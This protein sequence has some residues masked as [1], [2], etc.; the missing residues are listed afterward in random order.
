MKN[1]QSKIFLWIT[2][3]HCLISKNV[4]FSFQFVHTKSSSS[5]P[6]LPNFPF[7]DFSLSL[8]ISFL[9]FQFKVW[10]FL[11][12]FLQFQ[13]HLLRL[14]NCWVLRIPKTLYDLIHYIQL[15][16]L[17]VLLI[18]CNRGNSHFNLWFFINLWA[19]VFLIF[20]VFDN[21]YAYGYIIHKWVNH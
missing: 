2:T 7:L 3:N 1:L 17:L 19:C 4:P 21:F 14:W 6:I 13:P 8:S 10:R 20:L 15:T 12:R 9:N 16:V 11:F 18:D 5:P